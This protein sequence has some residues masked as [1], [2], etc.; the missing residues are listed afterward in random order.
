MVSTRRCGSES[1]VR[2]MSYG[3]DHFNM[4]VKFFAGVPRRKRAPRLRERLCR[5]AL[6]V[7]D[8]HAVTRTGQTCTRPVIVA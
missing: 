7:R 2:T 4:V 6:P 3:H 8:T 5:P 1:V